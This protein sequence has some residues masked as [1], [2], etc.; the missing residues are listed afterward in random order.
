M[1][2]SRDAD[3]RQ[4]MAQLLSEWFPANERVI[5]VMVQRQEP[6]VAEQLGYDEGRDE[7]RREPG[8]PGKG[9]KGKGKGRGRPAVDEPDMK[10][11]PVEEDPFGL[12]A[13]LGLDELET[14]WDQLDVD[15]GVDFSLPEPEMLGIPGPSLMTSRKRSASDLSLQPRT[16]LQRR[17]LTGQ[18][19][20]Y[21]SR[22]FLYLCLTYVCSMRF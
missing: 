8:K 13:E 19:M 10:A 12:D 18:K 2:L 20:M 5:Y 9:R 7:G 14:S 22:M 21:P 6:D 17:A 1:C 16:R 3:K 4:P 11:E 15:P